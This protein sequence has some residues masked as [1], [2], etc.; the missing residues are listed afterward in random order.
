LFLDGGFNRF[1]IAEHAPAPQLD[2]QATLDDGFLLALTDAPVPVICT[3]VQALN[4]LLG[5][6]QI[7]FRCFT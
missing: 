2:Y 6:G 7:P 5:Y 4:L 3:E 1:L